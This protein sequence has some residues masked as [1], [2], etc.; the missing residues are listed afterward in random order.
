MMQSQDRRNHLRHSFNCVLKGVELPM[1]G[2]HQNG[3]RSENI[4]ARVENLSEGGMCLI[5]PKPLNISNPIRCE[6][7]LAEFPVALPILLQVRWSQEISPG[8]EYRIGLK[9]LF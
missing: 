7:F 8:S 6:I 2:S 1:L 9:F 5:S 4:Q 3:N